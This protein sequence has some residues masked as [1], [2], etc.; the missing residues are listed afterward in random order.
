MKESVAKLK[1]PKS[2][3]K[4]KNSNVFDFPLKITF[5]PQPFVGQSLY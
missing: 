2:K 4:M 5:H 1:I 3:P